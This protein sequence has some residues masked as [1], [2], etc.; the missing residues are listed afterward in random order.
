MLFSV[1]IPTY[2]RSH[3]I[4]R[5]LKSVGMQGGT[6]LEV[7]IGDDASTDETIAVVQ[8]MMPEARIVKLDVNQGAAAARNVAMRI[9]RGEFLA[10][11]DSDDEWLPGKLE[12]QLDYLRANPS[13]AVCATGYFLQTKE[14]RRVAFPGVNPSDWRKELHSAQSFHGAST[15][16][17]RR[18]ILE[19][20]GLQD[21]ELRVLEDW[22]W[23]LRIARNHPIH[24]LP[25][26]FSVIHEN[27]PSNPDYTLRSME[28]FLNKH[29]GEFLFYGSA[30]ANRVIAQHE[31]NTARSLIRHGR[32]KQGLYMLGHSWRHA[33]FRNPAL[34]AAFPIAALDRIFGTSLLP[35]ILA[36]RNR[37]PL[38]QR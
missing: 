17:V 29:R 20:V 14:G 11:L 38:R 18:S 33:P 23:M 34:L 12:S 37:Q 1:I 36:R 16:L 9:A 25:E 19:S 26:M 30:H 5:A 3:C 8:E 24:V 32:T 15:P 4:R 21:E 22:D 27:N 31:E 6:D 7:I 35:E 13:C 10:F 28:R 2:N